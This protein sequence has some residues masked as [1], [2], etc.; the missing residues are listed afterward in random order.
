LDI[1]TFWEL[2]PYEFGLI[3]KYQI[4]KLRTDYEEKVALAYMTAYWTAQWFSKKKPEPLNK[5]LKL[6]SLKNREMDDEEMLTVVKSLHKALG[7]E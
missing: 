2:T 7:G 1:L 3:A 4:E 6:N 5:I